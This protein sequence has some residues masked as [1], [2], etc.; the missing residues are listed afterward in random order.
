MKLSQR[1]KTGA[2]FLVVYVSINYLPHPNL[3]LPFDS[4]EVGTLAEPDLPAPLLTFGQM[5]IEN[6]FELIHTRHRVP[7]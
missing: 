3:L 7:K 1:R 6:R 2:C 5:R 4:I